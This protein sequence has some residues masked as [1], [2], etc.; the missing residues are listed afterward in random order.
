MLFKNYYWYFEKA[1]SKLTCEKIIKHGK[2]KQLKMGTISH[3]GANN[4]ITKKEKE[5][6]Q[7]HRKSKVCF[8]NDPWLYDIFAPYINTANKNAGWNYNLSWSESFQFTVYKK[9]NFYHWHQDTF[10]EPNVSQ[11]PNFNGK[12]RKISLICNLTDP[13]KFTGGEVEFDITNQRERKTIILK[14]K[15]A[16][17]QGTVIVF[18]S[19]VW[20]RVKPVTSGTRISIV[21]W[22]IGEPWK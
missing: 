9:S 21:N 13:K 10:G 20:H 8:M 2:A 19:F 22:S 18:P 3:I 14:C 16:R 17:Q 11:D 5:F 4:K 6:V 15:E 12:I 1:L 7:Q